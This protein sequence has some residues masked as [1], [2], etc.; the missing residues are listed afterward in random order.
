MNIGLVEMYSNVHIIITVGYLLEH[1]IRRYLYVYYGRKYNVCV[2]VCVCCEG[3]GDMLVK[4]E[5]G[6]REE[7]KYNDR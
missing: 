4:I 7:I 5:W 3:E 2:C 6:K 1:L